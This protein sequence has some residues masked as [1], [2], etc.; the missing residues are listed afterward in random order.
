M[1][2]PV[3]R[4]PAILDSY[5][6]KRI[7]R[8]ANQRNLG[9]TQSLN[10]GL[11]LARG[12]YIARQDADDISLPSR[13]ERQVNF[14]TTHPQVAVVGTTYFEIHEK[15]NAKHLIQPPLDSNHV[16]DTL[17]YQHA[18][19]HG[20]VM[21]RRTSLEA[22]GGYDIDFPVAQDR[23]LWLRLAERYELA[24]M[25]EPLYYLRVYSASVTGR[26]RN[27]QRALAQ[28][29]VSQALQR[30]FLQPSALALGRFYWLEALEAVVCMNRI[31]TLEKIAL[32]IA[33][34]PSLDNDWSYLTWRAIHRA[35]EYQQESS[36]K[37]QLNT[38]SEPGI[39]VLD[40]LFGLLPTELCQLRKQK[41]RALG[42][43]YASLAFST[44][45]AGKYHLV[46]SYC[47]QAWQLDGTYR[48]NLGLFSV[49]FRSFLGR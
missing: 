1:M 22:V 25:P 7:V 49:F 3:T 17:I 37:S 35:Y 48:E 30:G 21:V 6:D 45:N 36:V 32:A 34:N 43:M 13:L 31:A 39:A 38:G 46:R 14:L 4:T 47:L 8:L 33:A 9:L 15:S 23:E 16:I 12:G 10:R 20:S 26:A 44:F 19:C 2:L 28:K 41:K 11:S 18:F 24:N 29:A 5:N 27:K 40:L 42:E